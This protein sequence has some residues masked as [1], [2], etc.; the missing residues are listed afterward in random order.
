MLRDRDGST[1]TPSVSVTILGRQPDVGGRCETLD[2]SDGVRVLAKDVPGRA[3]NVAEKSGVLEDYILAEVK[4]GTGA[5]ARS[6]TATTGTTGTT[7][8]STTTMYKLEW[9]TSA[10]GHRKRVEVTSRMDGSL[11]CCGLGG[12]CASDHAH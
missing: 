7:G 8:T 12:Q 9:L 3:P 6:S 10:C 11:G 1:N 4:P 2:C 5:S